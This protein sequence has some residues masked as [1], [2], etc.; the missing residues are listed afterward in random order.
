MRP[1]TAVSG[2]ARLQGRQTAAVSYPLGHPT[3]LLVT[4][5][6]VGR[7]KV[8][9]APFSYSSFTWSTGYGAPIKER[10]MYSSAKNPLLEGVIAQEIG[11]TIAKKLEVDSGSE[12]VPKILFDEIHP[13]EETEKKGFSK[14][15]GPGGRGPR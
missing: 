15:K 6:P 13:P 10:M 11:L 3:P 2:V 5:T 4:P 14:P 8:K 7:S 12:V 1:L 9:N